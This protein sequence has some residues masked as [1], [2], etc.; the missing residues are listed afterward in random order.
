MW[1]RWGR[2][3][4]RRRFSE[5]SNKVCNALE[6]IQVLGKT[7]SLCWFGSAVMLRL[8]AVV[9]GNF[10][11]HENLIDWMEVARADIQVE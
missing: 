11:G 4:G 5:V 1:D 9:V 7:D 6:H 8:P 10:S 3:G 2:C